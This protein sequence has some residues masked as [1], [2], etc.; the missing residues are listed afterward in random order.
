MAELGIL[1]AFASHAFLKGLSQHHLMIL[2]SGAR[3]FKAAAGELLAREDETARNFYLVQ[4]GRV[5]IEIHRPG[6]GPTLV[7]TVEPGDVVGWSWIVP[8]YRWQFDA[9]ALEPVTGLAFDAAW[10]REKCEMDHELGYQLLR[11][12]VCVIVTRLAS[13][14]LQMS[15]QS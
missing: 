2:A 14:R 13:T 5:A 8:P 7:H 9:R 11:Q 10:L 6:R 4:S 12:M 3:P 15:E 1:D